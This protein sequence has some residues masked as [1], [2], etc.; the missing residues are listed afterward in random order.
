MHR[1]TFL[2]MCGDL[3][4]PVHTASTLVP[5]PISRCSLIPCVSHRAPLLP[6]RSN[7][8]LADY[9]YQHTLDLHGDQLTTDEFPNTQSDTVDAY[10]KLDTFQE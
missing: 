3:P 8:K 6:T 2:C 10:R 5:L 4:S 7:L 1:C 9:K